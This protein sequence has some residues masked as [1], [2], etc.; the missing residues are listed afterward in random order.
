[1]TQ[2]DRCPNSCNPIKTTDG[3]PVKIDSSKIGSSSMNQAKCKVEAS[4][5]EVFTNHCIVTKTVN[6]NDRYC[7]GQYDHNVNCLSN[8]DIFSYEDFKNLINQNKFIP[9]AFLS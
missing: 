2:I 8:K 5:R 4:Q 6:E 1:R 3:Q 9:K 7:D